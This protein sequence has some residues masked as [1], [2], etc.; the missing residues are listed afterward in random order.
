MLYEVITI[1]D[2]GIF[3]LDSGGQYFGGTTDT[4]RTV[5]LGVP[6]QK[7]KRDF[8]LALKGTIALAMAKFPYGTRGYQI[9][10]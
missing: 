5:A 6:S 2:H 1:D 10:V 7:M 3:L 8:T 9:V 4:T